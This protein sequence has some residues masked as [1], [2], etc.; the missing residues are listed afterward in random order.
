MKR[1]I[2][3]LTGIML[4]FG[5]AVGTAAAAPDTAYAASA[6]VQ[7]YSDMIGQGGYI[8]YIRTSEKDGSA[9]IWRMK[10]GTDK[11][12]K[13][14]SEPNGIIALVVSG[15][16]LYYT[17]SNDAQKWEVRTCEL[18]GDDVQTVCEGRVCYVNSENVYYLRYGEK[19]ILASLYAKSLDTGKTTLIKTEKKDQVMDYVCNIGGESYYYVYDRKTDKVV[20]YGLHTANN[21]MT[22]IAAEKRVAEGSSELMIS[23]VRQIDGELYYDFGS[24]EG[25]GNF[26]NGTIRKL[27]VDG[28]K[29]TVA[30]YV[31][32]DQLIAGSRELYFST[33][34]GNY[35]KY[36]LK[37]GKKTKYSLKFEKDVSYTIL[38]DK[39]YMAD[40]SNKKKIV[41]SRFT[42]GTDRETLTKNF[43][44]IP[45]KQKAHISY[46]VSMRQVG[47]Y[48]MICVT[49]IDFTDA[50]YG[51]RGDLVSVNWYVTD[52]AGTLLGSFQ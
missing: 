21:K 12:S 26:W 1:V 42:S 43:I 33:S 4:V 18:D 37:T 19:D 23:D 31:G 16:R 49:G 50:A 22:R 51:W 29:K 52:G 41:I 15:Q 13:I 32:D 44:S 30:K 48:N 38:G 39:T 28:K 34:Q 6:F 20:L 46:S 11:R 8:Y 24:Y 7:E 14:V 25:S 2:R 17:T 3:F 40:T 27:T 10:V 5:L 36:N 45:F 35:Y 9:V 47:I